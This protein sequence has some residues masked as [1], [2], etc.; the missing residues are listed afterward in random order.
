MTNKETILA[1]IE[2]INAHN[3]EGLAALMSEDHTFIDAQGNQV[4]AAARGLE[5]NRERSS[6]HSLASL[7]RHQDSV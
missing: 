6:R 4:G 5:G 7:C 2:R 1:F 3:V